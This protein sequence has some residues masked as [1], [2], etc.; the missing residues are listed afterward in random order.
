MLLF[1]AKSYIFNPQ[2]KVE[3]IVLEFT[4]HQEFSDLNINN[5]EKIVRKAFSQRRK[6]IKTSLKDLINEIDLIQK[7][8]IDS[9]LRA[10]Q[11]SVSQYLKISEYLDAIN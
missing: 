6:K 5:L 9:N 11:L 3:G 10:E 4:P 1:I 2:P 7:L 8:G